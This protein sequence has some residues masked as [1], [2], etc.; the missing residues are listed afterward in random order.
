MSSTANGRPDTW[1]EVLDQM[2]T[3]L[4]EAL[5]RT[6]EVAVGPAPAEAGPHFESLDHL[7]QRLAQM[8]EGL[9]RTERDAQAAEAALQS[10][11]ETAGQWVL[12]M[13]DARRKLAELIA[14]AV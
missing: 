11:A 10:E 14:R 1:M 9:E 12:A 6:P 8:Q 3:A 7:E 4:A 2:E 13:A 5:A